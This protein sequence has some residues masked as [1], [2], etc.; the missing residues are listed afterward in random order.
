MD[1]QINTFINHLYSVGIVNQQTVVEILQIYNKLKLIH[2]DSSFGN[3][4]SSLKTPLSGRSQ[5]P[6]SHSKRDLMQSIL[7][8][9]LS[10]QD[11][12]AIQNMA[13]D[14]VSK[15]TETS[16]VDKVKNSKKLFIYYL[17]FYNQRMLYYL[18]KWKVNIKKRWKITDK[19]DLP[20]ELKKEQDSLMSCTFKPQINKGSKSLTKLRN[21]G[22]QQMDIYTRLYSDYAKLST[23]KII[24]KEQMDKKESEL[25]R[26]IPQITNPNHSLYT[27]NDL[28]SKSF[29]ERQG[30][31]SMQKEK[32]LEKLA[33][34]T[35]E[36]DNMIYT[37]TPQVNKS[38]KLMKIN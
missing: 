30:D 4:V 8:E 9:F 19:S 14:I 31:Y 16:L 34:D 12:I 35:A 36:S 29:L 27:S 32:K 17:R 33:R 10:R 1:K 18:K 23:K 6:I 3:S 25:L 37:F 21:M 38:F 28:C 15:Y 2:Q 13:F 11:G 7:N 26:T 24:R 20:S 5:E 22:Y